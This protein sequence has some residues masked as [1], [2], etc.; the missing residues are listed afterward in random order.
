MY[1]IYYIRT[2]ARDTSSVIHL[3]TLKT[4][5]SAKGYGRGGGLTN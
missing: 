4:A 3:P 5:P 2:C 1:K